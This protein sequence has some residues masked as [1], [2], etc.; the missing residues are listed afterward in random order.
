MRRS[1]S[2]GSEVADKR[3][4]RPSS[5]VGATVVPL[6]LTPTALS[7]HPASEREKNLLDQIRQLK[8]HMHF[9]EN[10]FHKDKAVWVQNYELSSEGLKETRERLE[11]QKLY[12]LRIISSLKL[13]Y[14]PMKPTVDVQI[15][16]GDPLAV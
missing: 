13:S 11:S 3:D 7:K 6:P 16:L 14:S 8:K 10:E 15:N 12:Y 5:F 1:A 9:K 2:L 4:A